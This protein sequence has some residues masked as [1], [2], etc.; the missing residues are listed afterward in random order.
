MGGLLFAEGRGV[1]E[2][3]WGVKPTQRSWDI[4]QILS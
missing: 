4:A 3:G 2:Q 1:G